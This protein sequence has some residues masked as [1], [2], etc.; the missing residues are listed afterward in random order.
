MPEPVVGFVTHA[1]SLAHDAGARHPERPERIRAITDHFTACALD[2][3][4]HRH[5]PD[6]APRAAVA[7]AHDDALIDLLEELDGQGGGRIDL[8]T[9]MGTA[10]LDAALRASQGA[11]DAADRVL[12]GRWSGAFVAM[13]P[14]G[15][16]ATRA[17][18]MGFC[19]TNHVAV[20]ARWALAAGRADRVLVV[21]WDAH[22]GN[23]TEDIFWTDPSVLYISI[24]QYPW[25]P[26]TGDATDV[27]D[28]DGRG[29][30]LNIPLP[31]ASAEDA[32]DRA[33]TDL[34][35]PA[36]ADFAPDLV[37]VSAGF[38]AHM[39]D[40]LCMMRLTAGAFY[41]MAR[42]TAALG[43]GPVCVLEGGYDLEGV[44]WSAG[45]TV[46]AL[47]GDA[48]A[49]GV[50]E[51]ERRELAGDPSAHDWIERTVQVRTRLGVRGFA[52]T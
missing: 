42:R 28:S 5:E 12:D 52:G 17:R 30:T 47:L 35:E 11:I 48:E 4:L 34:V 49:T 38:D 15:H 13:R 41:R 31:A 19:L 26:G 37:F 23:G 40:P 29:Y 16:H 14:P 3:R 51:A 36:A 43:P 24:H 2:G 27:G 7:L 22:H 33:F 18:P 46:A 32:Y 44:A 25:Y 1:S 39:A 21:D 9:A 6:P 8:D 10:S 50:P 20:A 45:A